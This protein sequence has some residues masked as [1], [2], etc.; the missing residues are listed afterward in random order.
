MA[1]LAEIEVIAIAA[2]DKNRVI[3]IDNDL[4]WRL[5][6][7]LKSFK[8]MTLHRPIIM[9]RKTYES[10]GRPLPR[11]TNIILTRSQSYR[12]DGCIVVHTVDAALESAQEHLGEHSEII[13]GGGA[14]I[15][16]LFL[17]HL[18]KMVLT[19][20]DC[21]LDGDTWFPKF[22]AN[23]WEAVESTHHPA[24]ERHAYAFDTITYTRR[25]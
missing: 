7:D 11:R 15:Y 1:D 2:M 8:K 6:D 17:P 19:H 20:V 5:P 10:I 14:V 24:D 22:S 13:I 18:T 23:Q 12:A 3:G 9:G 16:K 25:D 21:E 4:P